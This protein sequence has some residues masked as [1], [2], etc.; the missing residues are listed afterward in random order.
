MQKEKINY[1]YYYYYYKE[2]LLKYRNTCNKCKKLKALGMLLLSSLPLIQLLSRMVEVEV[3]VTIANNHK[4]KTHLLKIQANK[5]IKTKI[6]P[7]EVE[8]LEVEEEEEVMLQEEDKQ[9]LLQVSLKGGLDFVSGAEILS[10]L[11]KQ[12]ILSKI[13]LIIGKSE[14]NG[15]TI[16]SKYLLNLQILHLNNQ[17]LRETSKES[18]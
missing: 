15:G 16:N 6:T 10:L 12:T 17:P 2:N 18:I 11:M 4:I 3:I 8:G 5:T 13:V 7:Q 9:P 14:R 1:Y